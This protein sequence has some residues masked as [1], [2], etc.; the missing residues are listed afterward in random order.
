[1]VVTYQM[2]AFV[3]TYVFNKREN[4]SYIYFNVQVAESCY[5]P[6]NCFT[7]NNFLWKIHGYEKVL[8][9]CKLKGNKILK[10]MW[11]CLNFPF[12]IPC[13]MTMIKYV[14]KKNPCCSFWVVK[15]SLTFVYNSCSLFFKYF[16][17]II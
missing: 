10:Y 8:F 3:A 7:S 12:E 15:T 17:I 14:V 11:H 6:E 4:F 9:Y 1:M 5:L 2:S 16:S 13:C